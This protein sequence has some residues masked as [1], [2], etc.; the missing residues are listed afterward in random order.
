MTAQSDDNWCLANSFFEKGFE[1]IV[2][3]RPRAGTMNG[4]RDG[5]YVKFYQNYRG[6]HG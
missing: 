2:N 3:N 4:A 5:S 6:S 1:V